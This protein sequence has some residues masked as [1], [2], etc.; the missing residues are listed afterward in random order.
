MYLSFSWKELGENCESVFE[1][2]M[3]EE[4]GV[5]SR[6]A[7]TCFGGTK[8]GM[9]GECQ[10]GTAPSLFHV[11]ALLVAKSAMF[12]HYGL[13]MSSAKTLRHFRKYWLVHDRIFFFAHYKL[14]RIGQVFHPL[15]HNKLGSTDVNCPHAKTKN[16]S[17]VYHLK[18]RGKKPI[19]ANEYNS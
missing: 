14:Q 1:K 15:E 8:I 10:V 12:L 19:S 6:F 9:V 16:R 17:W 4:W 13:Y 2:T 18:T 3:P 5:S 7:K 11:F